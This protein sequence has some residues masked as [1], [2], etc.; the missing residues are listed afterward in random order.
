MQLNM[1]FTSSTKNR[2][3]KNTFSHRDFHLFAVFQNI[4]TNILYRA[5]VDELNKYANEDHKMPI[6]R[7][8]RRKRYRQIYLI[9]EDLIA[10]LHYL[11]IFRCVVSFTF[12][13][14][15]LKN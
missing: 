1:V 14:I 2:Y 6:V 15:L 12:R 4:V 11:S 13:L 9:N 10:I 8:I 5:S 7:K 3:E